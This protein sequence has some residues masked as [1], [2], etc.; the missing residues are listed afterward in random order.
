MLRLR[1]KRGQWF[2]I[3]HCRTGDRLRVWVERA[4][5]GSGNVE[6]MFDDPDRDFEFEKG[7]KIE[8]REKERI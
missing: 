3:T 5:A 8:A 6:L 4:T 7:E 1:R 2:E